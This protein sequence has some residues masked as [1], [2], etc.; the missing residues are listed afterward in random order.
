MKLMVYRSNKHANDIASLSIYEI[1]DLCPWRTITG[2]L[3]SDPVTGTEEGH[4]YVILDILDED[5]DG[6]ATDYVTV[7]FCEHIE[8][9]AALVTG[10]H[11]CLTVERGLAIPV[12]LVPGAPRPLR[13]TDVGRLD[14]RVV[15]AY[16]GVS[17][18]T[19]DDRAPRR[20]VT[21]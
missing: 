11:V 8:K 7:F 18:L 6:N 16:A 19:L 1:A 2:T 3:G 13:K 21:A 5:D 9:A 14:G 20:K 4:R 12:R 15:N 17:V 10:S